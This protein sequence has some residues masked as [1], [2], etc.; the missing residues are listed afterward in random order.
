VTTA[1]T[2]VF[3][4]MHEDV[5]RCIADSWAYPGPYS[6]YNATSDPDDYLEFVSPES[7]PELFLQA[8]FEGQLCGFMTGE[9]DGPDCA[10]E[11][12]LGLH[13]DLCGNG[14]GQAFTEA[15]VAEGAT[16]FSNGWD[17]K[18]AVA[19]FNERAQKV[20]RRAGFIPGASTLQ[21]TNGGNYS[22]L[23]MRRPYDWR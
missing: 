13:P 3:Q 4:A 1:P 20:Y 14:L 17:T 18:L 2:F 11:I 8:N 19:S 23:A 22:F 9:S 12:A 10:W 5:A 6:F 21:R 16:H 15:C 7:W